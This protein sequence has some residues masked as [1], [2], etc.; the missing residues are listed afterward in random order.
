MKNEEDLF[1]KSRELDIRFYAYSPV[2]GEFLLRTS[3]EILGNKSERFKEGTSIGDH[4]R[5]LYVKKPLL[6]ALDQF[7]KIAGKHNISRLALAYRRI[8]HSYSL[9]LLNWILGSISTRDFVS[10]VDR[11]GVIGGHKGLVLNND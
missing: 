2:A 4:Y 1:P 8:V 5:S 11:T 7:G 10:R 6:K 3:K 9:D